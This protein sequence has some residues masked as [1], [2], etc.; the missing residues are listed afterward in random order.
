MLERAEE[1]L[2]G[3]D[4]VAAYLRVPRVHLRIWMRG[5]FSPPTDVFLKLVDLISEENPAA[6]LPG[7]GEPLSAGDST[8]EA[9]RAVEDAREGVVTASGSGVP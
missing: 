6:R 7:D 8:L 9:T 1:I 4:E 3:P 2:G 5:M